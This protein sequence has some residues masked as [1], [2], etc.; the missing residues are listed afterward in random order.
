VSAAPRVWDVFMLNTELDMLEVRLRELPQVY[1][2]VLVEAAADHQGHPKPLHYLDNR[3]R[4]APW[5]DKIIHVVADHLPDHPN[6]WV[7]E[8]FQRDQALPALEDA[9]D[10]D[11]VLIAD[12]DEFPPALFPLPDPAISF[13]QRLAMYAVDWL[14]PDLHICTVA[15]RA[16]HV[17]KHG[18]A[19]VRDGR[20]GYPQAEGGWHIT[21]LGGA[22]GQRAKLATICHTEMTAYEASLLYDG[23]CYNEGIHHSGELQM[24]PVDVDST[25]PRWIYERKCPENWFRPR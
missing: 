12:V 8:H 18:L 22:E 6:P 23:K 20:Y 16:G 1:R 17:R 2:H 19:A 24:I 14:Y 25:W 11:I 3:E 7:R 21:W 15:A 10:D 4:F 5:K 13:R 9:S